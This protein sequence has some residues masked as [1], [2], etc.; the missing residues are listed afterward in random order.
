MKT[1]PAPLSVLTFL[2][3][4]STLAAAQKYVITDLGTIGGSISYATGIND[5][6]Q[7]VGSSYV[8]F[9]NGIYHAFI[10]TASTGLQDLGTLG[11]ENSY[12][13]A[14]NNSGQVVG[15]ADV[16]TSNEVP[17]HAFLWTATTGMQDLGTIGN[18]SC[19][20]GINDVGQVVGYST[21]TTNFD[22]HA[23]VWTS[24]NG[25]QDLGIP[26]S[27]NTFAASINDSGQ[28]VGT[29]Y[30]DFGYHAFLWSQSAG[31]QDLG[32]LGDRFATG[33][34]INSLGEV[35]GESEL[36][37]GIYV[38]Y[39]WTSKRGMQPLLSPYSGNDGTASAINS[40]G[41]I[42]G[43]G[44][45]DHYSQRATVWFTNSKVRDLNDLALN[46]H[47]TLAMAAGVN[48]LGQI[49]GVGILPS[50]TSTQHAY[51]ATPTRK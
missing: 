18:G 33:G 26:V 15:C 10:W 5:S 9:K 48:N 21:V 38:A 46:S 14:V 30:D 31:A 28:A 36:K 2:I 19:A 44:L 42:V 35:V 1:L 6:G 12:A 17:G 51:L 32:N 23:F 24:A 37:D 50:D 11:G 40:A 8:N 41:L 39:E 45:K 43:F 27:S 29:Y 7:V 16:S 47:L 4:C 49:V 34:S 25:M 13:H 20:F 3:L 22:Q